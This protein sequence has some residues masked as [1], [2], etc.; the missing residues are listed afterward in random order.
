ML[1]H[2]ARFDA[3]L[4]ALPALRA[5]TLFGKILFFRS[6]R[7]RIAVRAANVAMDIRP[8]VSHS[9]SSSFLIIIVNDQGKIIRIQIIFFIIILVKFCLQT[10][11][12]IKKYF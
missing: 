8:S 7:K 12:K 3:F 10:T 2:A 9:N 4:Y 11:V 1:D 5:I 6:V